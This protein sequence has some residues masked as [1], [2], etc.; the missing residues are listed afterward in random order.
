MASSTGI[1]TA[2]T[3]PRRAAA[4][5]R[6]RPIKAAR[7]QEMRTRLSVWLI[8]SHRPNAPR[9][10]IS[11]PTAIVRMRRRVPA[12]AR[13]IRP[14]INSHQGMAA[15]IAS[16]ATMTLKSTAETARKAPPCLATRLSIARLTGAR[17]ETVN[18]KLA[19]AAGV[20]ALPWRLTSM[21]RAASGVTHSR[22]R[23]PRVLRK[24]RA[25]ASDAA[26]ASTIATRLAFNRS[27]GT[28]AL[29]SRAI[30]SGF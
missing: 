24:A 19:F 15:R 16:R 2:L 4:T 18:G 22:H 5:P 21:R 26:W 25:W 8:R 27:S 17:I 29:P 28:V 10:N 6:G 14:I 23:S 30:I 7:K 11:T 3:L 13:A 9:T 20:K 12:Q 1:S